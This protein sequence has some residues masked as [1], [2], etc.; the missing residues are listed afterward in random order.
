MADRIMFISYVHEDSELAI[1]LKD[2]IEDSF[3]GSVE[4]FVSSDAISPGDDWRQKIRDSLR[5]ASDFIIL[6]TPRSYNRPW[7][8][9][10]AG[11]AYGRNIRFIPVCARG[12]SISH[13]APPLGD[14]QMLVIDSEEGT[15]NL[16]RTL[17]QPYSYKP[18]IDEA[19]VESVVRLA[20]LQ[21]GDLPPPLA[22]EAKRQ[23]P[24]LLR[25]MRE[26]WDSLM[27]ARKN[28]WEILDSF[29]APNFKGRSGYPD[30]LEG[31][32]DVSEPP[33]GLPLSRN[34]ELRDYP[35]K[36]RR[37]LAGSDSLLYDF[38][39]QVYPPKQAETTLKQCS[40]LP[41]EAFDGFHTA[42]G[43]LAKF[44]NRWGQFAYEGGQIGVDTIVRSFDAHQ[45]LLKLLSYLEI[46]LVQWTQDPGVGKEWLFRLTRDWRRV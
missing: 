8:N 40:A 2:L 27:S 3:T 26:E 46:C 10:E 42:R 22:S 20:Q 34:E 14:P 18:K 11:A 13:V 29:Y 9:F 16:V 17:A 32:V 15:R 38:C 7:V 37:L 19:K 35:T 44:W 6:L 24:A 30:S 1:R 21:P 28:F 45:R 41:Q 5:Q 25:Q 23:E 4:V 12:L 43:A 39:S 33:R 36:Y 31:L